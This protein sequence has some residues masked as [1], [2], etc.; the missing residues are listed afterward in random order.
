MKIEC[1]GMLCEVPDELVR[2]FQDNLREFFETN[3]PA[4][5]ARILRGDQDDDTE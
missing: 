1:G 5:R 2:K 4:W 3:E